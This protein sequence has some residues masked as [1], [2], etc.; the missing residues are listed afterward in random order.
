MDNKTLKIIPDKLLEQ[1]YVDCPYI[2]TRPLR[3]LCYWVIRNLYKGNI[4]PIFTDNVK[5]EIAPG[6]QY[7]KYQ[8]CLNCAAFPGEIWKDKDLFNSIPKVF[9]MFSKSFTAGTKLDTPIYRPKKTKDFEDVEESKR[10]SRERSYRW[11]RTHREEYNKY[12]RDYR[13]KKTQRR[14]E[15]ERHARSV[16]D[17][18]REET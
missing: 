9:S 7:R 4:D 15:I 13:R 6:K 16:R 3:L 10:K 11:R 12:V 8:T 17:T 5:K 1:N 14:K 18:G 2:G